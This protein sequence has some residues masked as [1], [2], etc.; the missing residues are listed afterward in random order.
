MS[1]G[2]GGTMEITD[3][4]LGIFIVAAVVET[5]VLRRDLEEHG[6]HIWIYVGYPLLVIAGLGYMLRQEIPDDFE[7]FMTFW[8]GAA[9]A[10]VLFVGVAF[11]FL[12]RR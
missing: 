1:G 5:V 11:A 3:I 12:R 8:I 10:V 6:L 9:S 2:E 7:D 4:L